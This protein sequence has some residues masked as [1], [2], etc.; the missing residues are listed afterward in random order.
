M[1]CCWNV[2]QNS[3]FD[4]AD[5]SNGIIDRVSFDGSSMKGAIFTVSSNIAITV[6]SA[7]LTYIAHETA[8][9]DVPRDF[10]IDSFTVLLQVVV[11]HLP[12]LHIVCITHNL[13]NYSAITVFIALSFTRTEC[14]VD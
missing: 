5:F 8:I 7:V 11:V 13:T 3:K 6:E 10:F 14:C 1:L 9:A 4:G 12:T 2:L